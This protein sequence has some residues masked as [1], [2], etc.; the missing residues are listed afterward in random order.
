MKY[1]SKKNVV[2]G[3]PV[4]VGTLDLH[5]DPV[6][7]FA[8]IWWGVFATDVAEVQ[9]AIAEHGAKRGISEISQDEFETYLKKKQTRQTHTWKV[10]ES[11]DGIITPPQSDQGKSDVASVDP[12]DAT[13]PDAE[14]KKSHS[15]DELLETKPRDEGSADAEYVTSQSALCEVLGVSIIKVRELAKM[16]DNPGK[17]DKGYRISDWTKFCAANR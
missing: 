3:M 4:T 16:E 10:T 9:Q 17:T 14:E 7:F 2:E 12:A 5:F 1:Y 11:V 15:I 13:D 6:M 8:G